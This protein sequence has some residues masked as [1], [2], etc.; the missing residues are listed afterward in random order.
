MAF[1]HI[2][3]TTGAVVLYAWL[4]PL[5]SANL[6]GRIFYKPT[7]MPERVVV[8]RVAWMNWAAATFKE[9]EMVD[10]EEPGWA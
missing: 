9:R 8:D 5:R 3:P 6:L 1:W 7:K 4:I 10:G 2:I